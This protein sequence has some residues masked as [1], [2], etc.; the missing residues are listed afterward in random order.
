[1]KLTNSVRSLILVS[2]VVVASGTAVFASHH[3]TDVAPAATT[4]AWH[5]MNYTNPNDVRSLAWEGN[6]IWSGTTGGVVRW[7]VLDGSYH[8]HT[9]AD[10]L[11]GNFVAHTAVDGFGNKWFDT[12]HGGIYGGAS[13]GS[14]G[15]SQFDG[16]TWTTHG[17]WPSGCEPHNVT[18]FATDFSGNLWAGTRGAGAYKYNGSTW[19]TITQADGLASNTILAIA[20]GGDGHLWFATD[21]GISEFDQQGWTAYAY[22]NDA[23]AIAVDGESVWVATPDGVGRL[24]IADGTYTK[25][26][27]DDGL[28]SNDIKSVA[29]DWDGRVW[30]GTDAGVSVFDQG[31]WTNYTTSDGLAPGTVWAITVD[32]RGHVWLGTSAGLTEYDE[33]FWTVH[34]VT[35]APS[36]NYVDALLPEGSNAFWAATGASWESYGLGHFDGNSWTTY[37]SLQGL[38]DD[39][40]D[41]IAK[42]NDGHLWVGTHSGIVEYDGSMWKTH[43]VASVG[44]E[45]RDIAL[46]AASGH[47]WFATNEGAAE[48]DGSMWSTYKTADGLVS[49]NVKAIALDGRAGVWFGTDAGVSRLSGGSWTTF[50]TSNGLVSNSIVD[51]AV[52]NLNRIWFATSSGISVYD[53]GTWD[54]F[55]EANS[56]L[57]SN[58]VQAI[59]VGS[60]GG[61]W[62]GTQG[63]V[64]QFYQ[65]D[66]ST[67]TCED[68]LADDDVHAVAI[69]SDGRIWFGTDSGITRLRRYRI[70]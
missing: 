64:N 7:N 17:G 62:I 28:A 25:F 52:D 30:F 29:V 42:D 44:N 12:A 63:G 10:G 40:V 5:W 33:G 16:T 1:M 55:T 39:N 59:A 54:T 56:S 45:I 20:L 18:S 27:T 36:S 61:I 37:G 35:Q 13:P 31:S 58:L 48:Y 50:T 19:A 68:G 22:S 57:A 23:V 60:R 9:T 26:D 21:A 8:I 43:V 38:P 46:D 15:V 41:A 66:W 4:D 70:T 6:Y 14:Y 24:V 47:L 69:G 67:F 3:H 65:G 2:L 49:D 11:A 34:E 32:G 53:N 51:I